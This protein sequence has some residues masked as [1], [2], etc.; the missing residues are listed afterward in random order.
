M[1]VIEAKR[2]IRYLRSLYQHESFIRFIIIITL[3]ASIGSAPVLALEV[4][5]DDAPEQSNKAG[6]CLWRSALLPGW[7]QLHAGSRIKGILFIAASA[8]LV[9]AHS[10]SDD[11]SSA[12]RRELNRWSILFW[13]YNLGDAYVDGYLAGFDEQ[14][15]DIES[16]GDDIMNGDRNADF[17]LG[18]SLRW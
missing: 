14:M 6:E 12:K 8:G 1:S 13:L 10:N 11:Y 15:D 9:Y 18:F 5:R 2:N 4:E 7:G 16:I 3:A 17:E